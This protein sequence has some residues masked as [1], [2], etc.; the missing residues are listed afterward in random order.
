MSSVPSKERALPIFP[1][2]HVGP[3]VRVPFCAPL[4]KALSKA[5]VPEPSSNFQWPTRPV[6]VT[7]ALTVRVNEVVL[8][9]PPVAVAVTVIV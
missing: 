2:V 5:V 4:S 1:V 9:N 3:F 8:V 7:G 6:V